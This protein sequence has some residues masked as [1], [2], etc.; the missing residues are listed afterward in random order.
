ME[1]TNRPRI[2]LISP[3]VVGAREQVRRTQPPLGL[4]SLASVM[5]RKGFNDILVL[6]AAVE[7]Y[8]RIMD[9][10]GDPDL[11][12]FGMDNGSVVKRLQVFRTDIVGISCLFSSQAECAFDLAEA[13]KRAMPAVLVVLGG[14]HAS[15]MYG[16]IMKTQPAIDFIIRGEGDY[17][18]CQFV[19]TYGQ[20][21]GHLNIPGLVYRNGSE[22]KTNPRSRPIGDL[23]ALPFPAWHLLDMEK[24]FE[25][26]MPHNPFVKSGRVGCIM[27]S[28]GCPQRCYFCASS[29]FF[30][31]QFRPM[32]GE[33]VI[34]MVD[35]LVDKFGIRELQIEDDTFTLDYN[36]VIEICD[37]I[38]EHD[39]RITFPNSIRADVP[40]NH[41][42]RYCMFVAMKSAGCE[43]FG[44]SVEHGDHEFLNKVIGKRLDLK[45]AVA[46]CELGHRA[47]LL[48]HA[49]FMMGFP[50][51][52]S[53]NR[54]R[55]AEFA[56]RLDA[57]SFSVSLATPLP[58]T[59][60]WDVA[61]QNDL[62]MD[63]FNVNR[64][65]Y[66]QVSIR[67]EDITAEELLETV[68]ALNREL[69]LAA[70]A[71]RPDAKKKYE[72][73]KGKTAHGDRKYLS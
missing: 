35:Y 66:S 70:K 61:E 54:A 27:T 6:D 11:I 5:E 36:R 55:T 72:L 30:G 17:S 23:D 63:T 33:R 49:N 71:R 19:E 42:N 18:F 41:D 22:I 47:G 8:G 56:R 26:G 39:L 58:G 52:T 57:D 69:N 59:A 32:S 34:A 43:Q 31:H 45:E 1:Q 37:G 28:R 14:I 21:N 29:T 2:A 67:P 50:L 3:Q 65:L 9:V 38:K 53:E 4:I 13:I 46:T 73:F 10:A 44:I 16:Q 15:N 25:I 12:V 24:Y 20:N 60:M 40:R 7:G 68:V 62:F 48:V 51:E 64:V